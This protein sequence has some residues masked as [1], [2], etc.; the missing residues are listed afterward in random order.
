MKSRIGRYLFVML[1]LVFGGCDAPEDVEV[2]PLP[3]LTRPSPEV[4]AGLPELEGVWHYAGWELA[5]EDSAL[6]SSEPARLGTLQLSVQRLDSLAGYYVA[7][8][9]RVRLTGEVRRDSLLSLVTAGAAGERRFLA[10]RVLGDTLW[11]ELTS[12][13]DAESWPSDARVAYVR[14]AVGS[15]FVRLEGV[16]AAEPVPDT[17]DAAPVA[18]VPEVEEP[19]VGR[20]PERRAAPA[21]S[22]EAPERAPAPRRAEPEPEEEERRAPPVLQ[23]DEPQPVQPTPEPARPEPVR[24]NP[25]RVLGEPVVRDT[26]GG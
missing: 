9:G 19:D 13:V 7:G 8:G 2:Q 1:L 17:V 20:E 3:P 22:R 26:T 12:L 5:P 16:V 15:P 11:V 6:L 25:P 4:R 24:P 21:P 23:P 10:G 14:E 18:T